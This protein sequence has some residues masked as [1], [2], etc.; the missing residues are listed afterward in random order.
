VGGW[1]GA[2]GAESGNRS[3]RVRASNGVA[4]PFEPQCCRQVG[5]IATLFLDRKSGI[6]LV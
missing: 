6:L 4:E 2:P 1:I 5:E 3:L